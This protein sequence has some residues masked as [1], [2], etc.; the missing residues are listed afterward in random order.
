MAGQSY[1]P[2]EVLDYIDTHSPPEGSPYGI[3]QRELAKALGYHPCSMSRP[4]E[5]L[6]RD[7]LLTS[8]RG[9]VRDGIRKQ[10]VYRLTPSGKGRLGRE[11][12]HIPMLAGVLPPPP[13]PF[14]GRREELAALGDFAHNG[15]SIMLVDG[16]PGMGKTALVSRHMRRVKRDRVPFWFAV[17]PA[18]SSR[19]FVTALSHALSTLGAPQLAYYAQLPR[20]PQA[21]EVADLASRA[22]GARALAVVI[23]DFQMASP[24]LR[25]F[26]VEFV[27]EL[28]KSKRDQIYLVGQELPDVRV[29]GLDI[30]RLSVGGLDRSAAHDL[31][32]RKG[33]LAERFE[34]VFTS[35]F[36]S[37][38]LLQLA[39]SNPGIEADAASLP[40]RV[41]ERLSPD[42]IRAMLPVALSNE[43][44]PLT[45]VTDTGLL[46]PIRLAEVLRMGILQ[47]TVQGRI[48]MLQ[49]VRGAIL[50]QVT[51]TDERAGHRALA[52]FYSGS[53][54]PEAIRERFLHLVESE[55]WKPASQLLTQQDRTLLGLGY[56]EALRADLRR[57]GAAL[58]RGPAKIRVLRTEAAL[59][60]HH[61]DYSESVAVLHRVISESND[62]PK[63]TCEVL[64]SIVD[65][66][67]RL[68]QVDEAA[69]DYAEAEQIGPLTRRLQ[70]YFLLSQARLLEARGNVHQARVR[71]QEAYE[72]ARRH[73]IT[74]LALE[75]IAT[76]SRL[77]DL[78]SGPE[79]ALKITGDALPEARL[80]GRIDIAFNL[81]LVRARA[82]FRMG[83]YSLA[84]GEM[85]LVRSEA[86]SLGYLVQLCYALDGLVA[87][88]IQ[89]GR[90]KE[91]ASYA[92]QT[93]SLA[94]R[95][96]NDVVLGHSLAALCTIERRLAI[97]SGKNDLLQD[98][99]THGKRSLD[100]LGKLPPSEILVVAHGYLAEV[101]LAV[102]DVARANTSYRT[103]LDLCD[104]IGLGWL[105][106]IIT[107]ELGS[108][109]EQAI[110]TAN[111]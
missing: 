77:E 87:A 111:T 106:E 67:I 102:G 13:N 22:L 80:A 51:P 83:Q 96:G 34:S 2:I 81:R 101:Y 108:K 94:E 30:A 6:V 41:V 4:L 44:L 46:T 63:I 47:K 8:K 17:R 48:E 56:S 85:K 20:A 84:E 42:D 33:G 90:L 28:A 76:W 62:D 7:G 88:S 26:L 39:V 57:L 52:D 68:R 3:S 70:A 24:D 25:S 15:G 110:A 45:F 64:L 109:V 100:V 36:G 82:Y 69:K 89:A 29:E 65:L 31:T 49:I 32:E 74:D 60:R 19:Q 16:Q 98:A 59:L 37:P 50:A 93:T 104:K 18:G 10:L 11:T 71:F 79:V 53:H 92:K 91:A 21:K 38:L 1:L 27:A 61:S 72:S 103:A 97:E 40:A 43:P 75:S 95:L 5:E 78:E 55:A 23:D 58:P 105:R 107:A 14:L 54:R 12:R 73:K 66:R 99:M 35:T 86:E 9:P